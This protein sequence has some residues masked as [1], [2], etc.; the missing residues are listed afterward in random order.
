MK[1]SPL[2]SFDIK[3]RVRFSLKADEIIIQT[4]EDP[5]RTPYAV[6]FSNTRLVEKIG[7]TPFRDYDYLNRHWIIR[8]DTAKEVTTKWHGFDSL[9]AVIKF[10]HHSFE[11]PFRASQKQLLA[12]PGHAIDGVCV[13]GGKFISSIVAS[14]AGYDVDV[15]S[16]F[17]I[18]QFLYD[19]AGL[20]F[21]QN[22][23]IFEINSPPNA[24][25][26]F[27]YLELADSGHELVTL[28]H[29][30][31]RTNV[32]HILRHGLMASPRGALGRGVY[33]G[34]RDKA[35]TF[36]TKPR[37]S[38]T[39]SRSTWI[40]HR[41]DPETRRVIFECDVI[42]RDVEKIIDIN[43][44]G[45]AHNGRDAYTSQFRRPEW[46]VRDPARVLIKRIHL[47]V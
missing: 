28:Y 1:S 25:A 9:S 16:F 19:D 34:Q 46:C 17:G 22:N 21:D 20:S 3:Q 38:L 18:D 37:R 8:F 26:F 40:K 42:L 14:I 36:S 7:A 5:P 2:D 43:Y 47:T 44:S 32:P 24:K 27:N 4:K 29:G 11:K 39:S 6:K 15:C 10:C 23:G 31:W 45:D 41:D 30:T 13:N 33:L 12:L 35:F